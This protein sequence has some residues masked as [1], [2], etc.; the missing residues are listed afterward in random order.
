MGTVI[1]IK[2]DHSSGL[3]LEERAADLA[4]ATFI[5]LSSSSGSRDVTKLSTVAIN[6]GSAPERAEELAK[7]IFEEIKELQ[8]KGPTA[9]DIEK[10]QGGQR[11]ARE[12]ALRQ[13][14]F[15]AGNLLSPYQYGV[16]DGCAEVQ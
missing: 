16:S 3:H 14:A 9:A 8:E 13:N 7:A 1:E 6:F 15:W 12:L 2:T 10:V 11:G 5:N 4:L